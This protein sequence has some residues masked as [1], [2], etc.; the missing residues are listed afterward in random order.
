MAA[1]APGAHPKG[2]TKERPLWRGFP[3]PPERPN[4]TGA[5]LASTAP[6]AS[7]VPQL[8]ANQPGK[9]NKKEAD[10]QGGLAEFLAEKS[11]LNAADANLSAGSFQ[12][13]ATL[14]RGRSIHR[15]VLY[16]STHATTNVTLVQKVGGL[17][18]GC[19]PVLQRLACGC[20]VGVA[21][22]T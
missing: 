10:P 15:S 18:R 7:A 8:G 3:L 16:L 9:I 1:A 21:T 22:A 13:L 12:R 6:L 2:Q 5:A 14:G 11:K 19:A 4:I 20:G 17:A